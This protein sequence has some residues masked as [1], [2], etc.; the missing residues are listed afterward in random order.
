M[1]RLPGLL[2]HFL[3]CVVVCSLVLAARGAAGQASDFRGDRSSTALGAACGLIAPCTRV[4][5]IGVHI[6]ALGGFST[7]R[8]RAFLGA[9]AHARLSLTFLDLAEIGTFLGGHMRSAPA[10][11]ITSF[12]SPASVY[13]RLRRLPID[14]PPSRRSPLSRRHTP[15]ARTQPLPPHRPAGSRRHPRSLHLR[16]RIGATGSGPAAARQRIARRAT[17]R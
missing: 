17:P 13:A 9:T 5:D 11:E 12:S 2:A 3:R 15:V 6:A 10:G 7:D 16:T 14:H 8:Q 4:G 1:R